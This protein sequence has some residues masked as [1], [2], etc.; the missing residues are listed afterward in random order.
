MANLW[1]MHLLLHHL[2]CLLLHLEFSHVLQLLLLR[3]WLL[4]VSLRLESMLLL[5]LTWIYALR[6]FF[7]FVEL[8]LK[9]LKTILVDEWLLRVLAVVVSPLHLLVFIVI[10]LIIYLYFAVYVE[11][12]VLQALSVV[13]TSKHA[14][15]W[16]NSGRCL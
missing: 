6:A 14:S 16:A 10:W 5:Q 2:L 9:L 15:I 3:M 12:L 4:I 11:E 13:A 8:L 1:Q 7:F